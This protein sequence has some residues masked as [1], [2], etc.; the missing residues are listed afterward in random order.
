MAGE[1]EKMGAW[2]SPVHQLSFGGW[3]ASDGDFD[4]PCGLAVDRSGLVYVADAG[5]GRVQVFDAEGRFRRKFGR[6]EGGWLKKVGKLVTPAGVAV[7]QTGTCYVADVK[8]GVL[9]YDK[10][11]QYLGQF[12]TKGKG[13][14]QLNWPRGICFDADG[15]L[16][17]V[18]SHSDRVLLFDPQGRLLLAFGG[19]GRDPEGRGQ[20][21]RPSVLVI[22]SEGCLYVTD[23]LNNRVQKFDARGRFL[24]K[25][26]AGGQGE[27]ELFMPRGI[28][29]D[30]WGR[31]YVVERMN[32]R[33]QVFNPDGHSLGT[34]GGEGKRDGQ[35]REPYGIAIDEQSRVYVSDNLGNRVQWFSL[36]APGLGSCV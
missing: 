7:D 3:G 2:T 1:V 22:D 21:Q 14:D 19:P 4:K 26:G 9:K 23:T 18:D 30:Q 16:W 33:V 34:F 36:S 29:I 28:A 15:N 17:V 6:G 10:D 5:N 12:A 11:G 13:E 27:G 32:H 24:A 20:F 35:F 31:V 8:S 25:F